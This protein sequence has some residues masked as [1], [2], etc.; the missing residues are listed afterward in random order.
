MQ[1]IRGR[2]TSADEKK[3]LQANQAPQD[4]VACRGHQE[5]AV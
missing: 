1:E 5:G 2:G 4:A 3:P